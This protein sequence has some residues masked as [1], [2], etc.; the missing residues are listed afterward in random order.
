MIM[1]STTATSTGKGLPVS[2]TE[3]SY[4]FQLRQVNKPLAAANDLIRNV[5]QSSVNGTTGIKFLDQ[6]MEDKCTGE[7]VEECFEDYILAKGFSVYIHRYYYAM[8]AFL[9]ALQSTNLTLLQQ[10]IQQEHFPLKFIDATLQTELID[11]FHKQ[12]L[13]Y[14]G[15]HERDERPIE[16][17]VDLNQKRELWSSGNS[18]AM[19][20]LKLEIER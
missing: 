12:S 15:A 17:E 11:E 10:H 9:D 13:K 4:S 5:P 16:F 1:I 8:R 2:D 14:I 19:D 6:L 7:T 20:L 18:T 3:G